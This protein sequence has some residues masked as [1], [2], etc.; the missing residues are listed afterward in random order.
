[1]FDRPRLRIRKVPLSSLSLCL[2][3]LLSGW[4]AAVASEESATEKTL[5]LEGQPPAAAKIQDFAWLEGAWRGEGLGG[6]CEEIW[7]TP[8]GDRMHGVFSLHRDG[9]PVFSEA[10]LLV[11]EGDS[12]VLK[13]KHFTP[14]FVAWEEKDESV[15][16]RLVKLEERAAYFSGLT[17][18]LE[19]DGS[20]TIYLR[21][22]RGEE[23]AEH[24]F[25]FRRGRD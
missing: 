13:V 2:L 23:V 11:E 15:I 4:T 9:A 10:M 12:V 6:E 1:M 20:L 22:K 16:F 8:F 19:E 3:A 21:L 5:R 25:H 14:D 18:R 24:A 17:L 7:G